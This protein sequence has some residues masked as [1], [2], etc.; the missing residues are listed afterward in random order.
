[1]S[2]E[3]DHPGKSMRAGHHPSGRGIA[4]GKQT[5]TMGLRRPAHRVQRKALVDTQQ[6]LRPAATAPT[7]D[8]LRVACRPDLHSTPEVREPVVQA[9]RSGQA[10]AREE[11]QQQ[12]LSC[13]LES[14]PSLHSSVDSQADTWVSPTGN[15][16]EEGVCYGGENERLTFEASWAVDKPPVASNE[17]RD[18]VAERGDHKR[19]GPAA[20]LEHLME[21]SRAERAREP[22]TR[23]I[24]DE[25]Y[26]GGVLD[27]SRDR[28]LLA[29]MARLYDPKLT[30][31]ERTAIN[32]EFMELAKATRNPALAYS[33]IEGIHYT[34]LDKSLRIDGSKLPRAFSPNYSSSRYTQT[35]AA[36]ETARK[37]G[38][39]GDL[40]TN[41]I[42]CNGAAYLL[43]RVAYPEAFS[44]KKRK[45]DVWRLRTNVKNF[46]YHQDQ[47]SL[48][49]EL[50]EAAQGDMLISWSNAA[51]VSRTEYMDE[52][53]ALSDTE[54]KDAPDLRAWLE[55]STRPGG[56]SIQALIRLGRQESARID[57]F[58]AHAEEL[59]TDRKFN[60]SRQEEPSKKARRTMKKAAPTW[61]AL[62]ATGRSAFDTL[63]AMDD[64][65]F[66]RV[67]RLAKAGGKS[68]WSQYKTLWLHDGTIA[69]GVPLPVDKTG[70]VNGAA[71][72]AKAQHIEL[73]FDHKPGPGEG[74]VTDIAM[75]GSRS[76]FDPN[77]I[78]R[79]KAGRLRWHTVDSLENA[80]N[81]VYMLGKTGHL[82]DSRQYV[83]MAPEM[84]NSRVKYKQGAAR[85]EDQ[86]HVQLRNS[87]YQIF[88]FDG[89]AEVVAQIRGQYPDAQGRKATTAMLPYND[90]ETNYPQVIEWVQLTS[91]LSGKKRWG[92]IK[93]LQ[94]EW[95]K[96]PSRDLKALR[97]ALTKDPERK[98]KL[99]GVLE[100]R[101]TVLSMLLGGESPRER[102]WK[103]AWPGLDDDKLGTEQANLLTRLEPLTKTCFGGSQ[104]RRSFD[105]RRLTEVHAE[106]HNHRRGHKRRDST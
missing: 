52:I 96:V 42:V 63:V 99:A 82:E 79:T 26:Q 47:K 22:S 38:D 61:L 19:G 35:A 64:A 50:S 51:I 94:R 69:E 75:V 6:P 57:R 58:K 88:P 3:R 14:D 9:K 43:T 20:G 8:W 4:P 1:M 83:K 31:E 105:H 37:T 45:K 29:K 102:D 30:R 73:V 28:K 72:P 21:A 15:D 49:H 101:R 76:S 56:A 87:T 85:Q 16:E 27:A 11:A 60:I 32:R 40:F 98:E 41:G 13:E 92:L 67:T 33:L 46:L 95:E 12:P 7:E 97:R 24:Q 81:K 48:T 78:K 18:K 100:A 54:E 34:G 91:A 103:A 17:Q 104:G 70:R 25:R 23:E 2:F 106:V 90:L 10:A 66:Q 89:A 71:T 62:D 39:T 77:G 55:L 93:A 65:S 68:R 80:K 53:A 5:K 59:A 36:M 74:P 44:D 84:L 86:L